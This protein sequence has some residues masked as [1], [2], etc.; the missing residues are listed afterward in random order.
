MLVVKYF[1]MVIPNEEGDEV[2]GV[3][4]DFVRPFEGE[5]Y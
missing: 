3:E 2:D 4:D 1:E 5:E